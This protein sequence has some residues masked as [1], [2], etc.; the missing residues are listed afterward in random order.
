MKPHSN[1]T[2]THLQK[3]AAYQARRRCEDSEP[4]NLE[5]S[6]DTVQQAIARK[7]LGLVEHESGQ[8]AAAREVPGLCKLESGQRAVAREVLGVLEHESGQRAAT[9]KVPGV[10]E[11]E[12]SANTV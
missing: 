12:Q 2:P 1:A 5:Q 7:K 9:R 3:R 6:A 10:V 11:H 8:C 4:R